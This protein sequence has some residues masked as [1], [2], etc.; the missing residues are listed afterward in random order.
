[1]YLDLELMKKCKH[2]ILSNSSFAFW[3]GWL[4]NN[5]DA[6]IIVP[7]P[8]LKTAPEIAPDNWHKIKV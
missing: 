5:P 8:W 6:I 1:M 7:D 2:A 4:N 3:A